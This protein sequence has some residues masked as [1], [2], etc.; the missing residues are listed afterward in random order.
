LKIDT[1]TKLLID[2]NRSSDFLIL[3][4]DKLPTLTESQWVLIYQS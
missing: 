3:P 2:Y 4:H 1:N